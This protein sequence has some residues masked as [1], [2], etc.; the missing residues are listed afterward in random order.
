MQLTQDDGFRSRYPEICRVHRRLVLERQP[1][2]EL[3]LSS[4]TNNTSQRLTNTCKFPSSSWTRGFLRVGP[5][6]YET[7]IGAKS[8]LRLLNLKREPSESTHLFQLHV[9]HLGTPDNDDS[10]RRLLIVV[11]GNAEKGV[12]EKWVQFGVTDS[13]CAYAYSQRLSRVSASRSRSTSNIYFKDFFRTYRP[14]GSI[15][16]QRPLGTGQLAMTTACNAQKRHS[17]HLSEKG[18]VIRT[19][20]KR[21]G[22]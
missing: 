1:D 3:A 6:R 4:P 5:V 17:A 11:P 12:P 18:S 19:S 22:G 7:S 14:D 10:Y 21:C 2:H 20:S 15:R 13:G 9:R 8:F 16:H